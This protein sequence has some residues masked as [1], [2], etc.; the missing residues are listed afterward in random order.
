MSLKQRL[1]IS[2]VPEV[3]LK[4]S[5]CISDSPNVPKADFVLSSGLPRC[6]LSRVGVSQIPRNVPNA[7]FVYLGVPKVSLKHSSCISES[8]KCH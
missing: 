5:L 6:H 4:H 2:R 8:P 1:C 3:S 7:E